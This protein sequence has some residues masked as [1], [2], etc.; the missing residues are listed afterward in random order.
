[1]KDMGTIQFITDPRPDFD[2]VDQVEM[3]CAGGLKWIQM[4]LKDM[5][6]AEKLRYG[7][8]IGR[9]AR[10]YDAVFIVNDDVEIARELQADGVH[11]GLEDEDPVVARDVL[12]PAAIIGGT[13]NCYDD[14][15][16]RHRQRVA[17]IGLGPYRF[18]STK[19]KLSP[20]LGLHGYKNHL[21]RC[22]KEQL[23]IPIVAIG[24]IGVADI[25]PLRE[26]GVAGIAVSSLIV[27]APDPAARVKEIQE[28]F[29]CRTVR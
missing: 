8:E 3:I 16:L 1:M 19:K 29:A 28:E 25:A 9:I 13:C 11:L 15:L 23:N 12:G 7:R 21:Q 4:R 20:V 27:D 10:G 6:V 14:I 24:G 5:S 18:T 2:P 17:Y 26:V 22:C